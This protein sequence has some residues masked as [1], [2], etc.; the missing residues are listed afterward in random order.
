MFIKQPISRFLFERVL[1]TLWQSIP[2]LQRQDV[3]HQTNN[4]FLHNLPPFAL[5]FSARIKNTIHIVRFIFQKSLFNRFG[6]FPMSHIRFVLIPTIRIVNR[7]TQSIISIRIRLLKHCALSNR[8]ISVSFLSL[9]I[10]LHS[11]PFT[12][13]MRFLLPIFR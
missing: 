12:L 3:S 10:V 5:I 2:C 9:K 4:D 1:P 7:A 8:N 11:F 13:K 6:N